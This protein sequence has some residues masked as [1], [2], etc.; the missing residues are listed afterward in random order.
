MWM[1]HLN[2]IR[3]NPACENSYIYLLSMIPFL[4]NMQFMDTQVFKNTAVADSFLYTNANEKIDNSES[5]S[6]INNQLFH[7]VST[8][9]IRIYSRMLYRSFELLPLLQGA[10]N[11]AKDLFDNDLKS[12][13]VLSPLE[14]S[15]SEYN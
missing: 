11:K 14:T 8:K 12:R 5:F 7:L 13:L 9:P 10:L 2:I 6:L 4:C 3:M 15:S 1:E